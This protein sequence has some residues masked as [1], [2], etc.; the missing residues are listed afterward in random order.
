MKRGWGPITTES[1]QAERDRHGLQW[2]GPGEMVSTA[3]GTAAIQAHS[4]LPGCMGG[5]WCMERQ[6]VQKHVFIGATAA[7]CEA[8]P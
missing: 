2:E 6:T 7:I 5:R 3:E 8:I 4:T 1:P